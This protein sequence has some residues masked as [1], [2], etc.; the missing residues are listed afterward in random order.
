MTGLHFFRNMFIASGICM[1]LLS[2]STGV[3]QL[4]ACTGCASSGCS[5]LPNFSDCYNDGM[6]TGSLCLGSCDCEDY[7]PGLSCHCIQ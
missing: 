1:L 4:K 5:D 2:I 6:C 3:G 7:I